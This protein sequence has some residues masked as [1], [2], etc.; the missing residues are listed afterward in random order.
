M[1]GADVRGRAFAANM[2]LAS[3]ERQA[4]RTAAVAIASLSDQSSRHL[5]EVSGSRGHETDAGAAILKRQPE[6][7][8]FTDSD[9]DPEFTRRAQQTKCDALGGGGDCE[10]ATAM[11]FFS[12]RSE[13]LDHAERVGITGD[14]T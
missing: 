13:R 7:L 12:N 1:I 10:C 14:G 3:V 8:T 5:A 11:R 6:T 9:I 2:L 4:E